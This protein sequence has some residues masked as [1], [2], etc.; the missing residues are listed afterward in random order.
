MVTNISGC[1][2]K[3][4]CDV[5]DI[6]LLKNSQPSTIFY[7]DSGELEAMAVELSRVVA[8]RDALA[9]QIRA[10]AVTMSDKMQH[11]TKQGT[12]F[13]IFSSAQV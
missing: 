5:S 6:E 7:I 13:V 10:D 9:A 8:E 1:F 12:T 3:F 2:Q 4:P 11:A